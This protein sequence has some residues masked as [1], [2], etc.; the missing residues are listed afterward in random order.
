[1][2]DFV[3]LDSKNIKLPTAG[4]HKLGHRFI[5]PYKILKRIGP[6]SYELELPESM[7]IHDVFHVSLLRPYHRR[8][9]EKGAP[10]AL[11]PSGDIEYEVQEVLKHFDVGLEVNLSL[12][13]DA[14]NVRWYEVRWDDGS[15]SSIPEKN[16]SNCWERVKEYFAKQGIDAQRPSLASVGEVPSKR[17][18]LAGKFLFLP[19]PKQCLTWLR[20]WKVREICPNKL[21]QQQQGDLPG[22]GLRGFYVCPQNSQRLHHVSLD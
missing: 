12:S 16:T 1:V 13:D 3:Y 15:I 19:L 7:R 4:A 2:G 20:D 8:G 11:L 6:V 14:D 5:G 22:F 9:G 17:D 10:P 18:K 21:R